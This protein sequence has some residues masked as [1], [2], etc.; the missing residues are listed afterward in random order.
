MVQFT[1]HE[2]MFHLIA[3]K[4]WQW[5]DKRCHAHVCVHMQGVWTILMYAVY[6]T[7]KVHFLLTGL[8]LLEDKEDLGQ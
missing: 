4:I 2:K 6:L 1:K 8:I 3:K 7:R 5:N